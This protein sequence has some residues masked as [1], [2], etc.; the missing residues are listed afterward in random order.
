MKLVGIIDGE[1]VTFDYFPPNQFKAYIPKKLNGT[2]NIHLRCIDDAGNEEGLSGVYIYIDFQKMDF[3]VLEKV[4]KDEVNSK[5][6]DCET[7]NEKYKNDKENDNY[8]FKELNSQ[9]S[10]KVV[11]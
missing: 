6:Y 9:Y 4:Y 10:Y 1:E 3:K 5:N 11:T 2:Y 8:N 7:L